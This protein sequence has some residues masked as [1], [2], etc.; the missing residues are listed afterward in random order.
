MPKSAGMLR[1]R[2]IALACSIVAI[3][4]PIAL[5]LLI[6]K[7]AVDIP[8]WDE[9]EWADL[10]YRFHVGTLT[11]ADLWAQ[12]NEHRLLF[13]QLIMLG[14]DKFG[15][16]SPVREQY[17]SLFFVVCSQIG[18][19]VM[20]RR[21]IHGIA[22]PITGALAS[23]ILYG[24]WQ[25]ENFSWGFQMAWFLC[26]AAV[27]AVAALLTKPERGVRATAAAGLIAI[28]ASF[29]SSQGLIAWAVGAVAI[30]MTQ[31]H[32]ARILPAW[33]LG[34]AA[35]YA[36]YAHDLRTSSVEH[37]NLLAH[38]LSGLF[39]IF[40]YLGSPVARSAGAAMHRILIE[41]G[42]PLAQTVD[43]NTVYPSA[44]AGIVVSL[45]LAAALA[46]DLRRPARRRHFLIRG[47]WYALATFPLVCGVATASGRATLGTAQALSS[48]Y[49]S[50]SGL[51]WI[52]AGALCATYLARQTGAPHL[53]RSRS[54]PAVAL[55]VLALLVF[56][57]EIAG[58]RDWRL[59]HAKWAAARQE[60]ERNDPA[61]LSSLYPVA[62]RI[63]ML[64][65]ELRRVRDGPFRNG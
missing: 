21:T 2:A 49:T 11:F 7:T 45:V 37:F 27:I 38:P 43:V 39:Y 14:L 58:L 10:V 46:A 61:A 44:A 53:V 52:A 48:R 29:S 63:E 42:A 8:Y 47:P 62:S 24:L 6:A 34:A 22:G 55:T 9:W 16:W 40:T 31:R 19:F 51:A 20:I 15:G 56:G 35:S 26:N 23:I 25:S 4:L 18:I 12:H 5:W 36:V 13:P 1:S 54:V 64:I 60:L 3:V 32:S 57:S 33:L 30:V 28:V 50:V 17:V 41:A 65:D 59:T